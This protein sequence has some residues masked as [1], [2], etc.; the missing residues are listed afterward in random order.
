MLF[1]KDAEIKDIFPKKGQLFISTNVFYLK[2]TMKHHY[3][4]LQRSWRN[5]QATYL[6]GLKT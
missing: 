6:R 1:S 2:G 3:L 5:F 4:P